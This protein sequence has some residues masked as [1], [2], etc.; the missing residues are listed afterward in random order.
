M[1]GWT[2]IFVALICAAVGVISWFVTPKGETQTLIRTS[3]LLTVTCCYLMWAITY[4]AQ[5]HPLISPRR[6]DVRFDY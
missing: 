3:V 5:M 4:M 2:V 6:T 1:S